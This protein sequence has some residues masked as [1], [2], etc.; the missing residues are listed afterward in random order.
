MK[1]E[2]LP[3]AEERAEMAEAT[4]SDASP[5]AGKPTSARKRP[6][7]RP[8]LPK[9]SLPPS[10]FFGAAPAPIPPSSASGSALAPECPN[11]PEQQAVLVKRAVV[12]A[13]MAEALGLD[14]EIRASGYRLFLVGLLR[15]AGNPSDPVEVMLL[16]QMAVCHFRALQLQG[17]AG[18]AQ[19][20]EAIELYNAAAV[21]LTA[22]FRKTALALKE[23]RG[24]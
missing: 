5:T 19:G 21:R 14:G 11:P 3:P 13:T 4:R 15:D 16:E 18:Q 24:T 9:P 22:E 17:Q 8:T 20:L 6:V 1:T 2:T 10:G 12:P 7:R 23:Y